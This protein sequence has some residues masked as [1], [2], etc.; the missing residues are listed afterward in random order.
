MSGARFTDRADC[1]WCGK[2]V[3]VNRDGT[4]RVHF[5]RRDPMHDY[6]P[7]TV[8]CEGGGKPLGENRTVIARL[9]A[10]CDEAEAAVR[11]ASA[12]PALATARIRALIREQP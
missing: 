10:A 11:P 5:L 7:C 6:W 3:V 12:E 1:P 8:R 2:D 9:L 4:L